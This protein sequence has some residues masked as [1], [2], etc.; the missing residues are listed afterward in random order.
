M[1]ADLDSALPA[2][3][4][5]VLGPLVVLRAGSTVR[6]GGIRQ[7]AVLARLICNAGRVVTTDQLA[8]AVWGESVPSGYV[9]TLQTYVFHLRAALEPDRPAGSAADVAPDGG[10]W[11]SPR[12][13][14]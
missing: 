8:T 13:G 6:L 10:R 12:S 14:P 4:I 3:E 2:L 5:R 11:L 1:P 9:S 7:R